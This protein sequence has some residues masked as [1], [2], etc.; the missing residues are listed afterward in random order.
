MLHDIVLQMY[1][2]NIR[3]LRGN[4]YGI[5]GWNTSLIPIHPATLIHPDI[6]G[7]RSGADMLVYETH[8]CR[9]RAKLHI[10]Q[11]L[12]CVSGARSTS[13]G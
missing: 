5:S 9:L 1:A 13:A 7:D 10:L 4:V 6:P 3:M 12:G 11:G 2:H 8:T